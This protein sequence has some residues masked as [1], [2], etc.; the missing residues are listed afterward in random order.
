MMTKRCVFISLVDNFADKLSEKV[1][2]ELGFL[3]LNIDSYIEYVY[4]GMPNLFE[5][6]SLNYIKQ[7][8]VGAIK[9][10]LTFEQTLYYCGYQT[11]INNKNLFEDCN[12]IYLYMKPNDIE[13]L[14]GFNQIVD[15]I[16]FS[17]R[18]KILKNFKQICISENFDKSCHDIINKFRSYYED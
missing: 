13:K 8:E 10:A 12:I 1:S 3:Y 15:E 14:G 9:K 6:A 11:F 16:A 7:Q 5:N 2:T 17:D 4:Q 18:D